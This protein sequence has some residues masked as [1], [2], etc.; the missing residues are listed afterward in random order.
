MSQRWENDMLNRRGILVWSF[1]LALRLAPAQAQQMDMD[2]MMRWG[3][4]D[5]VHYH[6]VGAY[7]AKTDVVGD[8]N[9]VGHADVTDRV[10]IELD[11]KLSESKLVGAPKILNEKSTVN[12]LRNAEPKCLPPILKGEY[13]H[14]ELLGIKDG[15]G[16]AL[17]LQ[18]QTSYP[19]AEVVQFCTGSRK[20]AAASRKLRP[21]DFAVPS[22]VMLAMPLPDSDSLRASADKKS[23][24][25][26]K[27]G[28][29]WTFTPSIK[30]GH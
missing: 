14:Y 25:Q 12:N 8:A 13:E 4:A 28:W 26:K 23:L 6:I 29:I 30:A 11:W 16:G 17:E 15:L 5:L 24:V 3:A 20:T 21:E 9:E 1:L 7:Q 2:A 18:V 27:D 19:A 22:P 10:V